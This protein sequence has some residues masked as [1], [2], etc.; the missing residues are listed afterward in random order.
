MTD[1][2]TLKPLQRAALRAGLAASG[3]TFQ[4]T[5]GGYLPT[6]GERTVFTTRTIRAME[7]DGLI[8]YRD[9]FAETAVLT[10]DGLSAAEALRDADGV[11]AVV[12]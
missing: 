10:A 3:H 11:K 5:R 1:T 4:R 6:T 2:T 9:Q 12:A 8:H 7:R